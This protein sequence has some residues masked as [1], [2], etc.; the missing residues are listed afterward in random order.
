MK[1]SS[2]FSARRFL[3]NQL[4]VYG[5]RAALCNELPEHLGAPENLAAPKH[6]ETMEILT[7]LFIAQ[8]STNVQQW[9]NLEQEY[10]R[11]FEHLSEDQKLSK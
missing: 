6:L 7:D 11:K 8:N 5:A 9:R 2:C 1:T 10:K 3:R 4:S